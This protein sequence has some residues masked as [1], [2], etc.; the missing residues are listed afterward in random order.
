MTA[1]VDFETQSACDLKKA[2]LHAYA[3]HATTR[4][5]CMAWAIDDEPVEIWRPGEPLPERLMIHVTGNGKIAG[6]NVS[7]EFTIWNVTC[8]KLYEFPEIKIEQCDCTMARAY[9]MALPGSLDR[10]SA[11]LGIDAKKDMLGSRIM[12]QLAQPRKFPQRRVGSHFVKETRVEFWKPEDAPEKFESLYAYCKQDVVVERLIDKRVL[13]LS[14]NERKV[15]ELD[16]KINA[17]GINVDL[18]AAKSAIEIATLEKARLDGEVQKITDGAVSTCNAHAQLNDWIRSEG[19]R[20]PSLDKSHVAAL[21]AR[22]NLPF[23]IRS[24]LIIRQEA[25]KSSVAKL[26]SMVSG[27]SAD[28]RLKGLLQYHGATTGRWSGRRLQPQ[29][30]PRPKLSPKAIEGVFEILKAK[31]TAAEKRELIDMLYGAPLQVLSECLRGFLIPGKGRDFAGCDFSQIEA[32]VLA[33]LANE[34]SDLEIFRSG[35]DIYI[36]AARDIYGREDI[37]KEERQVGKVAVLALGY[38][39]GVGAFSAMAKAYNVSLKP[40]FKTLWELASPGQRDQAESLL[41]RTMSASRHAEPIIR[42]EYLAAQIVKLR[43]REAHPN[44]CRYWYDVEDAAMFAVMQPGV[45]FTVGSVKFRTNGSFL[46]CRLPSGRV[47]CYPYPQIKG[48]E[49][50]WGDKRDGLT[51]MAIGKALQWERTKAYGGLLVENI[52]QAVARDLMAE[53]MLRCEAMKYEVVLTVHDEILC[54]IPE[55]VGSVEE[56]EQ[57]MCYLPDWAKGLPIAANGFRGQRYGKG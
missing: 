12:M 38:Q 42:E 20:T 17:R 45:L 26:N 10:A 51:H 49:T 29:N 32:R 6:H 33:W 44:V 35:E 15:W 5:L 53:A 19:V 40:A 3:E 25:A 27:I 43:W 24:A 16:Q 11:A 54:E 46:W 30:F 31:K 13:P 23:M 9:A 39:G 22:E 37:G 28:G 8:R 56:L 50:P 47:L 36:A 57:I 41:A 2:G 34:T 52:C 18:P 4:V 21:L 7:F 48:I 14:G 1:H 55:G